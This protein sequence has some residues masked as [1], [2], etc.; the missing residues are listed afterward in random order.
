LVKKQVREMDRV[1]A[2]VDRELYT[3]GRCLVAGR[4]TVLTD[5]N[6]RKT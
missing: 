2:T 4:D 5:M 1:A 6:L 3:E